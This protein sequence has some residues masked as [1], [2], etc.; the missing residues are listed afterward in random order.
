MGRHARNAWLVVLRLIG[1]LVTE[2]FGT[3]ELRQLRNFLV[4][5]K[6]LNISEAARRL[7]VSQPALSRQILDLEQSLERPLFVRHANGLRLTAAG[8]TLRLHGAKA[9]ASL[10]EA[11]RRT[12]SAAAA[13]DSEIRIGYYGVTWAVLVEPAL[14]RLRREYTNVTLK[15]T[16]QPPSQLASELQRGRLDLAVLNRDP[17][18]RNKIIAQQVAKVPM[19][20]ALPVDH[21]L[22]RRRVVSLDDLR[23]EKII[24]FTRRVGFG[25]DR[26]FISACRKVG[27]V[28]RILYNAQTLSGLLLS[29][30][31]HH[32]VGLVTTFARDTPHPGVAFRKLKTPVY[33]DIYAAHSQS[34]APAVRRLIELIAVVG[35]RFSVNG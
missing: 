8:A 7:H 31:T 19:L 3:M 2:Y 4:V 11:V 35:N 30:A 13:T 9:V 14:N 16:E 22:A 32:G 6:M 15:L 28:P 29:V 27:F 24:S 33:L 5:S 1:G 12:R 21:T 17:K 34:A 10:D 18:L 23:G 20:V 26:P 25:R